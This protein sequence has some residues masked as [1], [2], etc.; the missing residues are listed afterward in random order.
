VEALN[1]PCRFEADD[2]RLYRLKAS[3]ERSKQ[4]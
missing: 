4:R 3:D 2:F 1:A